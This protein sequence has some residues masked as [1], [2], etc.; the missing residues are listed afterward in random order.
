M[1]I[2]PF[3]P[4]YAVTALLA[5]CAGYTAKPVTNEAE[6][7]SSEGI[8]Y[9][10]L[11]PYLIVYSDGKGG[12]KSNVELMPDTSRKM[13][14]NPH[15]IASSNNSS[16]TFVNGVLTESKFITDETVLPAKVIDTIKTLGIAAVSNAMNEPGAMA[17]RQIPAPYLFKIVVGKDGTRLVGGQG[18]GPDNKP[19]VIHVTATPEATAAATLGGAQ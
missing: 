11:A 2:L 3:A 17:E 10:E 16:L 6:D 14:V 12:I 5:G 13:V 19:L 18:V 7:A 8:R 1:R 4:A 9:Y 15:A